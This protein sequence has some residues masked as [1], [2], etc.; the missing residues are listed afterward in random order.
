MADDRFQL[1][2]AFSRSHPLQ[3]AEIIGQQPREAGTGFLKALEGPTGVGVLNAMLP[4][5]AAAHLA[6]MAAEEA[7]ALIAAMTPQRA[8]NIIRLLPGALAR[9]ALDRQSAVRRPQIQ[10]Y[11]RQVK[12]VVGAWIESDVVTARADE[13]A[14]SLRKKFSVYEGDVPVAYIVDEHQAVLG[15]V[16]APALVAAE[17]DAPASDLLKPVPTVLR[18]RTPIEAAVQDAAWRS[19][20]ILPVAETADAFLGIIRY[21]VLR[22]AVDDI[23]QESPSEFFGSSATALTDAWFTGLSDVLSAS[24]GR[25]TTQPAEATGNERDRT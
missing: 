8:A 6:G 20:D 21:A 19:T 4:P 25:P 14:E 11:L 16:N 24:L 5:A 10:F 2:E 1:A 17:A 23:T 22:H 7:V 12:G 15:T 18:A 3:A 9:Q 13:P